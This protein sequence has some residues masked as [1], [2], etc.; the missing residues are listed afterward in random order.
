[1]DDRYLFVEW[2]DPV[3]GVRAA[4]VHRKLQESQPTGEALEAISRQMGMV[5]QLRLISKELKV[6]HIA[7]CC[8]CVWRHLPQVIAVLQ[9]YMPCRLLK[10]RACI[11]SVIKSASLALHAR[12]MAAKQSTI[13]R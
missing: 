4:W 12:S 6:G 3:F 10:S 13:L 8:L 1:M 7:G 9:A 11:L 5:A 2:E